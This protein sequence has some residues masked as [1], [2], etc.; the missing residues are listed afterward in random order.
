MRN[1]WRVDFGEILYAFF[2]VAPVPSSRLSGFLHHPFLHPWS[3]RGAR[4]ADERAS[5]P[6][7]TATV[8]DCLNLSGMWDKSRP[9]ADLYSVRFTYWVEGRMHTGCFKTRTKYAQGETLTVRHDPRHPERNSADPEETLRTEML[10]AAAAA[11]VALYFALVW[12]L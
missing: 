6:E 1:Y 11:L 9:S 5:W 8:A 4:R 10:I 12:H 7:T 2:E 3:W